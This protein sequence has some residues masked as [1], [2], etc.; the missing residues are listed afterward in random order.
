M[1]VCNIV[2]E[3]LT[4][5]IPKKNKCKKAKWLSEETLQ[6]AEKRETKGKGEKERYIQLNADFQRKARRDKKAFLSNQCK[7][8]EENNRMGKTRDLFKKIRDT[9]GTFHAKIGLI[10]DRNCMDLTEAEDIRKRWQEYAEELYKKDLHDQDNRDGVITNLE[11]DILECEVKWALESITANKASGGDGI[12]VE[13]FQI[14]K[15]D[16][17]KVLHS[18]CQQIRKTQQW[19]Q[20]WKRWFFIPI[21]EKSQAKEC[22]N[23][24]TIVVITHSS[25]IL[26]KILKARLQPYGNQ[27]FS[28]V[29]AGFTKRRRTRGQIANICWIIRKARE[30]QKNI[31]ICLIDYAK[32]SDCVDHHKLWKILKEMGIPGHLTCL[33]RNLYTVQKHQLEL[34]VEQAEQAGSTLVKEGV[35]AVYFHPA[36]LASVHCVILNAGLHEAQ[37]GIH[38]AG[39][40]YQQPQTCR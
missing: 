13:L 14:L 17:M 35:R 16:A 32:I 5:I 38:V 29:Q 30:F 28:D 26:H 10:K 2:Q 8:I 24:C 12:P 23:Y 22:S 1:E 20:D 19:P 40:K 25:K 21:P 11:P 31:Y 37:A 36:Y 3:V 6:I 34:D 7:Q 4:K 9:K 15:D 18:I 27:E 33:L 39:E